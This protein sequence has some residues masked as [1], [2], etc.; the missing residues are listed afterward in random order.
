[1]ARIVRYAVGDKSSRKRVEFQEAVAAV[2]GIPLIV[3]ALGL[4]MQL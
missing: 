4:P 2:G 3:R 1:M